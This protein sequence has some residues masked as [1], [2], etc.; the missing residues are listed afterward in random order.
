MVNGIAAGFRN[1]SIGLTEYFDK[2]YGMFLQALRNVSAG[3]AEQSGMP[4]ILSR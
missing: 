1:D 3:L 2:P 4:Y